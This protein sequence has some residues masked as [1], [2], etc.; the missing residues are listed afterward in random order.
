MKAIR[1]SGRDDV[2][3]AEVPVPEPG[4]GEILLRVIACGI[5]GS[6]LKEWTSGPVVIPG[7]SG[8]VT[9]GHEFVGEVTRLG[10]RVSGVA[11][12]DRVAVEG[13]LRCGDCPACDRGDY[14]LCRLAA[15]IGFHRDG[16]LAEFVAV[17][18]ANLIPVPAGLADDVAGLVEPFAVAYHATLRPESL[19]GAVVLVVGAGTVGCAVVAAARE[20]GA[21]RVVV[22]EPIAQRRESATALGADEVVDSIGALQAAAESFDVAFECSGQGAGLT[23]AVDAVRRGGTVVTIGLHAEPRLL[24]INAVTMN[25][26]TLLGSLGYRDDFTPAFALLDRLGDRARALISAQI[27]LEDTLVG[28]FRE[29]LDNGAAHGKILIR[30]GRG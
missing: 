20:R 26:R 3:L 7:G 9:L 28:G 8:T 22:V 5:C 1:W 21:H 23:A 27:P 15:Y 29:L 13:E 2:Q 18:A 19:D 16:G 11:V 6:D 14:H 12:G 25:E 10:P 17:P 24:D 30:P 4:P